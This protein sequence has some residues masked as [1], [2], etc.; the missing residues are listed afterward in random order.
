MYL[1]G[2]RRLSVA[3]PIKVVDVATVLEDVERLKDTLTSIST[4]FLDCLGGTFKR[5]DLA[6][7]KAVGDEDSAGPRHSRGKCGFVRTP[8]ERRDSML[9]T[10][11]KFRRAV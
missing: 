1:T 5:C 7:R 4:C 9:S 6:S 10:Y 11:A 3:I 2:Y 8:V